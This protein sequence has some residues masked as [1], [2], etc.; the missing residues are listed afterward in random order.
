MYKSSQLDLIVFYIANV[1]DD[2]RFGRLPV[3]ELIIPRSSNLL[4]NESIG[5]FIAVMGWSKY[6][7]FISQFYTHGLNN[8]LCQMLGNVIEQV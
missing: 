4:P 1:M 8:G 6:D 3:L 7:L 5:S 2:F